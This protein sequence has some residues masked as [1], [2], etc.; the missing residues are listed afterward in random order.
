MLLLALDTSTRYASIALCS[1]D[2]LYGEYTWYS[3]NNHSVELLTYTKRLLEDCHLTFQQ[4]DALAVATGPGSFNGVRVALAT[5][6]AL[7]FSLGKPLVGVSGL[8]ISAKQQRHAPGLICALQEAGRSE[9]Y[10][11]CYIFSATASAS[12]NASDDPSLRQL[13]DY[14]LDTPQQLA[15][16]LKELQAESQKSGEAM[17]NHSS[18]PSPILFCGE[19]SSA[20][21]QALLAL[22]PGQCLFVSGPAAVRQASTL[23][24]LALERL[25]DQRWDD[26]LQL[27]PLYIRRP[28]ITTSTRKQSLL[29]AGDRQLPGSQTTEREEGAL[30]H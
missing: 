25:R 17:L 30:R 11:A 14:L 1:A 15:A 27:E 12:D 9:V 26:P 18:Q 16:R 21:R 22:L 5:A 20:T 2:E 24:L 7:A 6:K 19:I 29:G 13:G 3:G 28:S 8:E 10:A 23:V 4:L